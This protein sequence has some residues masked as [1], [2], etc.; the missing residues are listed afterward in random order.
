M[1]QRENEGGDN[2]DVRRAST[3]GGGVMHLIGGRL[4]LLI[5]PARVIVFVDKY[6]SIAGEEEEEETQCKL[7]PE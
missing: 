5:V 6:L 4:I 7:R 2:G 1:S 3:I